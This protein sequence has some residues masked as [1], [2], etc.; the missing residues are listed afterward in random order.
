MLRK[1]IDTNHA[2]IQVK[3]T[4]ER[5]K[6]NLPLGKGLITSL[7]SITALTSAN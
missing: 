7:K 4:I 6:R 5:T 3:V 2:A 1:L